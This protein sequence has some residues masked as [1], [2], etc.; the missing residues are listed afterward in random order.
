METVVQTVERRDIGFRF[1]VSIDKEL[2]T[3]T[4]AKYPDKTVVHASLEGHEETYDAAVES[5]KTAK[6]ELLKLV[7]EKPKEA[8]PT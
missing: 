2:R 8:T 3:E 7:E 1:H 6:Q 4:G 5:L